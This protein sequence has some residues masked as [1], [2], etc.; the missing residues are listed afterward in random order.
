M[1]AFIAFSNVHLVYLSVADCLASIF[2]DAVGDK[3]LFETARSTGI[4]ASR[5][6]QNT[7]IILCTIAMPSVCI[8][9]DLCPNNISVD[10]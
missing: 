9:F 8:C 5:S 3:Y 1:N 4:F 2:R 6:S 7:F 10:A